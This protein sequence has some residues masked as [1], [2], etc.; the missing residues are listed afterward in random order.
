M[1]HPQ[2]ARTPAQTSPVRSPVHTDPQQ[3][4]QTQS[5]TEAELGVL[6]EGL[7]SDADAGVRIRHAAD[8]LMSSSLTRTGQRVK[9]NLGADEWETFMAAVWSP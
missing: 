2:E 6:L 1:A 3:D 5:A 4:A 7:G 9:V 8:Q